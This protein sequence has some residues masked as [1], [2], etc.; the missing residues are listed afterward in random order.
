MGSENG[1]TSRK[2]I[3]YSKVLREG[4]NADK[5]IL[6]LAAAGEMRRHEAKMAQLPPAGWS[7]LITAAPEET[8]NSEVTIEIGK[9]RVKAS[10]TTNSELLTKVCRVL[11][12]LC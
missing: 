5:P 1:G 9:C 12:E 4:R 7:E 11:V 2:R 8:E 3:E 6:L 10:E